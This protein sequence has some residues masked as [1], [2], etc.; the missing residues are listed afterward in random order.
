MSPS[1]KHDSSNGATVSSPNSESSEQSGSTSGPVKRKVMKRVRKN[2]DK[3]AEEDVTTSLKDP[4]AV[5]ANARLG[6]DVF[7]TLTSSRTYFFLLLLRFMLIFITPAILEGTEFS[8]GVDT[9]AASLLPGMSSRGVDPLLTVPPTGLGETNRT[10]SI[11]GAFVSSGIPYMGVNVWCTKVMSCAPERIGYL[12]VLVPRLWMFIV[13]LVTDVLLV[14]C[15]AVYEGENAEFALITYAS[16]WSTLLGMTRN[17]NFALE[18]MCVA[19][20]VA[21]CFGWKPNVARP[22]FWLSGTALSLGIFLRPSFAFFVFTP[23]IYLS[24]LWGKSG[25]DPLRYVR[26]ALEGLAIF[27]FW[28]T[29]WVSVDSVYFGTFKLRFGEIP[30]E[31]FDMFLEYCTKGLPF[32]YKGKLVYTPINALQSVANRKFL[33]TLTANTSP[34]QMFLSLP[35]ILGPLFIV[36]IRESYD[37][38]KVAMKELMTELKQVT[39]SK[40]TKKRKS[41][42]PGMTEEL[43]GELYVYFDT[44]QTTFL[45]GL[46]IEVVQNHDRLG[47][48]SLLS[49]IPP[50]VVCIA[51]RVFGPKSFPRF[52]VLHIIFTV[53][54]VL[55]YGFFNQSG[56]P[57]LV[58]RAGS[59]SVD[60]IPYNADLVVYRGIIGHRSLLG[61]NMKNISLHDGG[62]SRI[63]LLTKLRELKSSENYDDSKL[64]V[65]AAATVD[66]KDTEF[67]PVDSG[68]YGHMSAIDLPNNID[69]AVRKSSLKIYHFNGDENEAII[70]DN[71]E[72]AEREEREER[73][74]ERKN[75]GDKEDMDFEEDL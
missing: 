19:M 68:F 10:R 50:C 62:N 69:E 65:L 21:A 7:K 57:R 59:G 16:T 2:R 20:L 47:T 24:S 18:A 63:S 44:I 54:M 34:G 60:S 40:K 15:F 72:A 26:A 37:G 52:R 4:S 67:E 38:M 3:S 71:E 45:L 42:K 70:R 17:M 55:F 25:I 36:L 11:V 39:N 29:I 1:S 73:E 75:T 41:K 48:L 31:S 12:A 61:P 74:R 51:G 43:E 64:L 27:A 58:L 46:L 13:S 49:L 22:V 28:C 56:I 23:C 5:V 66:M 32:S 6:A 30:M 9:L 53:G 8:D 14:R 35:A 33:S